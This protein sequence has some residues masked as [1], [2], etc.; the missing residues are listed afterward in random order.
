MRTWSGPFLFV[1]L[2]LSPQ[3]LLATPASINPEKTLLPLFKL[4]EKYWLW[5][6]DHVKVYGL[7]FSQN[8][9]GRA[10]YGHKGD[11]H[12]IPKETFL[13]ARELAWSVFEAFPSE[14][15][16]SAG[17]AFHVGSNLVLTNHHVFSPS[18]ERETYCG[19]FKIKLNFNQR[20]KTLY[21]KE[22]HRCNKE[23]DYCLIE[24]WP[25]R[26]GYKL[27][28]Q[29]PPALNPYETYSE[30]KEMM[31]I[32]NTRGFGIHASKGIGYV[33]SPMGA[34]FYA[35]VFSGNSGGPL[36]NNEGEV[37]AVVRA[38]SISLLSDSSYNV[39]IPLGDIKE[40]LE[41]SLGSGHPVLEKIHFKPM[42]VIVDAPADSDATEP[43]EDLAQDDLVQVEDFSHL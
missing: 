11:S 23:M 10:K 33:S 13:E 29:E 14:G 32:G 18:R 12:I 35:P 31:A 26:R 4:F 16:D 2:I 34:S 25:H 15:V 27:S 6:E 36:F 21:C 9:Y 28:A 43:A 3:Q 22:V 20:N 30:D 39:A 5:G 38:Q 24:M 40:D 1:L 8:R 42:P 17:T 7:S 41:N 37:V 19:D